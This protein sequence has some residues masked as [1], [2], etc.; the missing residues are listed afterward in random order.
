MKRYQVYGIVLVVM[1]GAWLRMKILYMM[2]EPSLG[3]TT[4]EQQPWV[5]IVDVMPWY[6]LICFGCYCLTKLGFDLLTFN[7]YPDEIRRL[8]QDIRTAEADLKRRG[9]DTTTS[10]RS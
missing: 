1:V 10:A 6:S 9:F 8:E 2:A 5:W 4:T 3:T 7:D